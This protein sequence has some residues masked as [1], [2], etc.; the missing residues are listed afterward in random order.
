MPEMRRVEAQEFW[1]GVTVGLPRASGPVVESS[2]LWGLC[3]PRSGQAAQSRHTYVRGGFGHS[4]RPQYPTMVLCC[5]G[6]SFEQEQ[7]GLW[8]S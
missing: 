5:R 7:V 2:S 3:E 8:S 4:G 1:E 6:S